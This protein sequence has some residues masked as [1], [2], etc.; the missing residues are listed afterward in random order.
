[1]KVKNHSKKFVV[2]DM[3]GCSVVIPK[4]ILCENKLYKGEDWDKAI[5]I[6]QMEDY[7]AIDPK[8]KT[9]I[10]EREVFIRCKYGI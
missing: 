10:V 4:K 9:L 5:W 6:E 1:M 3:F 7:Y 2:V 8:K